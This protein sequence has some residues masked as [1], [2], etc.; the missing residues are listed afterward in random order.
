M[1]KRTRAHRASVT[2]EYKNRK[3]I[4]MID[5]ACPSDL[6]IDE[7]INKKQQ[8][9]RQ[10]AYEIRGKRPGHKV[11]I[12]PMVIRCMGEGATSLKDQIRRVLDSDE[13]IQRI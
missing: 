5:M 8:K 1:R 12:I 7:K 6:N 3:L 10:L 11:E 4:Q 13:V 2:I 9:Y